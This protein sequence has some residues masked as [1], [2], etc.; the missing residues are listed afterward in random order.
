MLETIVELQLLYP[1]ERNVLMFWFKNPQQYFR[2][3]KSQE[4]EALCSEVPFH[5][6]YALLTQL[7]ALV[8]TREVKAPYL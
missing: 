1:Q 2:K 4:A 6:W 8:G 5:S 3:V 7:L